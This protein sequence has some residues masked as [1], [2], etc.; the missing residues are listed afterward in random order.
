MNA[1]EPTTP[2]LQPTG[3]AASSTTA[4]AAGPRERARSAAGEVRRVT[5]APTQLGGEQLGGHKATDHPAPHPRALPQELRV[6]VFVVVSLLVHGGLTLVMPSAWARP[7][8]V[9][10]STS[11]EMFEELIPV[12]LPVEPL[13]VP[14]PEPEPVSVPE[15]PVER[16]RVA[17][18][19]EPVPTP[20]EP[21][22]Q[23][24]PPVEPQPEP[25]APPPAAAAVMA[26]NG[27]SASGPSFTAGTE[28]GSAHGLGSTVREGPT[29]ANARQ[30]TPGTSLSPGV[31]VRGLM[32]AYVRQLNRRVRP[33]VQYPRSA[34]IAGLEGTVQLALL[35]DQDG[36]VL[37]RRLRRS[38]GHAS[39]DNAVLA[40][41]EHMTHVPPPPDELRPHWTP[42]EI[43][44]PVRMSISH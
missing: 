12:E 44:V 3:A 28:G 13:A 24:E 10:A 15:P 18:V 38:C 2:M 35:I 11:A 41:A 25:P 4:A 20:P 26:A 33:G 36:N 9:Q 19:A 32:R 30:A 8:V 27:E 40:A 23:A 17:P 43:T 22:P 42:Q 6:P 21:T 7:A 37:R 34:V 31:D 29:N 16:A 1:L 5:E 14:E 39:L